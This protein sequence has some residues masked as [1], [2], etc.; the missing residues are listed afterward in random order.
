MSLITLPNALLA[1]V[2]VFL[3]RE[4][5]KQWIILTRITKNWKFVHFASHM[6]PCV[7][8]RT[9][10]HI[11]HFAN[12]LSIKIEDYGEENDATI[13]ILHN[14]SQIRQYTLQVLTPNPKTWLIPPN[15]HY[16]R[17]LG[18]KINDLKCVQLLN[19]PISL[20]ILVLYEMNFQLTG[21]PYKQ[22]TAVAQLKHLKI[23]HRFTPFFD[24]EWLKC[25]TN[26]KGLSLDSIYARPGL[27]ST[28]TKLQHVQLSGNIAFDSLVAL[29][30]YPRLQTLNIAYDSPTIF[31]PGH[32]ITLTGLNVL[33]LNNMIFNDSFFG[34]LRHLQNLQELTLI[35]CTKCGTLE[36]L[37]QYG[38]NLKNFGMNRLR[39]Y[40]TQVFTYLSNLKNIKEMALFDCCMQSLV[41]L[42]ACRFLE[43]LTISWTRETDAP[44]PE[45]I[46]TFQTALPHTE[47]KI[48][49]HLALCALPFYNIK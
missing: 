30:F 38:Q 23:R 48:A 12:L 8:N 25:A 6:S 44:S 20:E 4:N 5:I 22:T 17:L 19:W 46:I 21:F 31:D 15:T 36:D 45:D 13:S 32:L 33:N 16:L 14:M 42:I 47:L 11:A 49:Q 9:I 43:R 29:T 3:E 18:G 28:L 39:F 40:D 37:V 34:I 35:H 2:F 26:L 10:H 27:P 7:S 1:L 24:R 41:P